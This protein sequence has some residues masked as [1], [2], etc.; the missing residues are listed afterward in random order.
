[1]KMTKFSKWGM[2]VVGVL[3]LVLTAGIETGDWDFMGKVNF[4][5]GCKLCIGGVQVTASATDINHLTGGAYAYTV[6]TYQTVTNLQAVT[7]T[8]GTINIL[9]P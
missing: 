2:G 7:L 3:A 6:Q 4:D 8:A 5:T 1:M 9:K